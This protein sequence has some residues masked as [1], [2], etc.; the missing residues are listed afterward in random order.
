MFAKARQPE[1]ENIAKLQVRLQLQ[2]FKIGVS[3]T[4]F[5]QAG[6]IVLPVGTPLEFYRL[7]G[8][9][10]MGTHG[11][12]VFALGALDQPCIVVIPR[13]V[14]VIDD[15]QVGIVKNIQTFVNAAPGLQLQCAAIELPAAFVMLL[16]FPF[17]GITD[18]GLAF[19]IVEPYVFG[20]VAVG[21]HILAR[22]AAGVTAD[23]L[24][25]VQHHGVLG[26]NLHTSPPPRLCA[27]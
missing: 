26:F 3:G 21:P 7:T 24:V 9:T 20:A 4:G 2:I 15:R 6:Q 19:D 18:S 11:W 17:S 27:R 22:D 16:I 23:T 12:L 13:F 8:Q 1:H 25:Q 5:A 14:V 10:R